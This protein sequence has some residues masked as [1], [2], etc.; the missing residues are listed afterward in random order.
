VP[1]T[2]E[3]RI[4]VRGAQQHNL[5]DIDVDIGP[6]ITAVV[7]V[8]GS[9]KSSLAFD[10]VY[11]EAHRRFTETLAIGVGHGRARPAAVRS[12]TGLG[13][14][15]S[16]AQNVLNRN[17]LST[18]ATATGVHPFLRI[19][20]ARFADVACPDCGTPVRVMTDDERVS[21]ART[22]H[23][24]VTVPLVR[25]VVGTHRRLLTLL[26][27][28]L[29][30]DAITVD[31]KPWSGRA[32][33]AARPHD[34]TVTVATLAANPSAADVR[35]A[36]AQADALG[37]TEVII[38]GRS[39][40]RSPICPTCSAWVPRLP[41]TAFR[42]EAG[43]DTS[44]H[45]IAGHRIDDLLTLT[46][47]RVQQVLDDA[48]LPPAAARATA[49]LRRR[50]EP[51]VTVGLD[52]VALDRPMPTLS[53]GESQRVRLAV[54]VA[55][56]LEDLLHVLDEPSIGLHR[57]DLKRLFTVLG[58]LPGPVLMVEHD[59]TA[60]AAA[61]DV[62]EIGPG[63]GPHGGEVT[64]RGTP[65]ELWKAD[66]V[67]GRHLSGREHNVVRTP[68]S[69]PDAFISVRGAHLRNLDA[70][71]CRFPVGRLTAV[72]GP[73]GAGK[74][75][76]VRDVLLASVDAG[77]PVGCEGFDGD[78][79]R[80][81]VVDQSPL[82][83]NPRSNPAT[84]T[85]V[86]DRLRALFAATTG[87]S[88]STFTFNRPE[89]ACPACEG[90]G[91]V[92]V[93]IRYLP[94]TWVTC[95]A[96]EGT[97]FKPEVLDL[98]PR[99]G[100]VELTIA[101]ALALSVDDARAAFAHDRAT[102]RILDA[103]GDVGLGYLELGQPS[104]TLSGGEAQRVRLARELA[105]TKPGDLLV[106][107]EPTTG[108]HPADLDRLVGV[109]DSLTA[110]GCTVIVVEHQ[111]DVVAAA[112]WVVELGPGGGP[113]GG[114][115]QH[116]GPP[117][118]SRAKA[119]TPRAAPRR[120]ARASD[121]I[122]VRGAAANNLRNVDVDIPKGRFT[123]VTGVSGSGKSS[124]VRDVLEAEAMRRLLESLSM[125]ERQ[126]VREGPE[127]PVR[128]VD[129]LGPTLVLSASNRWSSGYAESLHR[130]TATV[131]RASDVT[132]LLAVV[133]ARGGARRCRACGGDGTMTRDDPK[134]ESRWTCTACGADGVPVEP[135]HLVAPS[136]ISACPN[137]LGRAIVREGVVERL[138]VAPEKTI[139]GGAMRSVGYFP[140]GY[141]CDEGTGGNKALTALA[142]RHDFDPTRTPWCEMSAGAQQAFLWGDPEPLNVPGAWLV[143]GRWM[144]VMTGLTMW[145]QGGLYTTGH[146]CEVC[147]G[148]RLRPDY[149]SITVDGFDRGDLHA[150]P[151]ADLGRA[152]GDVVLVDTLAEEARATAVRRLDFL[153]RV[154]LGYLH[155]DRYTFT[156]SAGEAQR[157]KLSSVLGG[158]LL[159]MTILLDE[160][161]R[162]LHP[163]EVDALADALCELRDAG[164]TVITVEHDVGVIARADHV[165]EIGPGSG[166]DGGRVVHAGPH[167]PAST[168]PPA[169]LRRDRRE[170]SAW[171][172]VRGARSNNLAVDKL[173]VPLGVL[174]GFFGVSG[175]GKSS[176]VVDT[177]GLALA[178]P[179]LTTSVA[180]EQY[181]PGEHDAI[182]GAPPRTVVADQSRT[183]LSSAGAALG[184]I[185]T[186]RT[187]YAR[188]DA[189]VAAGLT[190]ADF[191]AGCDA[192]SGGLVVEGMGFLP[193]VA[194]SC[195]VCDGTGYRAEAAEIVLRGRT[196]P[197]LEGVTLDELAATWSD[198]PAIG[199]ACDAARRLG[200]GYLVVRQAGHS[201][202][203]GEAQRLK[204]AAELAK[205]ALKPT[206]YLLDEPT[207]GL[208]ARDVAV[209]AAALHEVV[210]A[211]HSVLVVEHE[212]SLLAQCDWLIELG[213]GAGPHGGRVVAEGP[214]EVVARGESPTAPFLHAVLA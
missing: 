66:T 203:G 6:G 155:L 33:S 104:P 91:A 189:A 84:Y 171:M 116:C 13:P 128:S 194:R 57:T 46:A 129:G 136:A 10:T 161:S 178:P 200:I 70:V 120:H 204:L 127:A 126:G 103:L 83:N 2:G 176:L 68:R 19:L 208:H 133:L 110:N 22:L 148:K 211:G 109:L 170:P 151:L 14:A 141:L 122:R 72:T 41:A 18:V 75:T 143:D 186:L 180:G 125:Y 77:A 107:D 16:I 177:M 150:M 80:A 29:G 140:K 74:T 73:S 49:E 191:T 25:N 167:R 42:P 114:R 79:R 138:I 160:S 173:R 54:V 101:D 132:R 156:L 93:G 137:C 181:T 69:A 117:R 111:P 130:P 67:S 183:G 157:V 7:G 23:G 85:K 28:A 209:L 27:A 131:G 152:L 35:R 61:D 197:Q 207:V 149:L 26:D 179:K 206:L 64:F 145:D 121:A 40:L 17:P 106:L 88:P 139:C 15:V 71:D 63:A 175:S 147:N 105:R 154:G 39:L 89:G 21:V 58:R 59:A 196:L 100:D 198:V 51:L 184:I 53:R 31:G 153:C 205:K 34:I 4:E 164:N 9:G 163:R 11:H 123:A 81:L 135:R 165:I 94:S 38:D 12:I 56:R 214:P 32:P 213:P 20:Y 3:R 30:R 188:S 195:D 86:L 1:P 142:R 48:G 52:H 95:D 119:P 159:G 76:L 8:S 98:R 162:G 50:L 36:L 55:G 5:R 199:R 118:R 210:D 174:A 87:R 144:G 158:G 202:S 201:L 99:I 43:T 193:A 115:V 212:P 113:D 62:V 112:D 185:R 47:S 60:V 108:L 192:C 124:L 182:E 168:A 44:S 172:T 96:C 82:G 102:L 187:E 65:A 37:A 97:R 146:V 166:P 190:E 24:P 45:T 90:M 92:E 78:V 169:A 134:P